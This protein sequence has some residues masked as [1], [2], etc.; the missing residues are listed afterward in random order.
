MASP[1]KQSRQDNRFEF[2]SA[3]SMSG[4]EKPIML[5]SELRIIEPLQ[6]VDSNKMPTMLEYDIY[7]TRPV[8]PGPQTRFRVSG[9]FMKRAKATDA[10]P[11]PVWTGIENDSEAKKVLLA[12]NWFEMLIKSID[13][14]YNHDR[15]SSFNESSRVLPH[16]N[17]F[18]YHHM[19][20]KIKK[21]LFPEMCHPAHL[22]PANKDDFTAGNEECKVWM[23]YSKHIFKVGGKFEFG[24]TPTFLWPFHQSPTHWTDPKN[25]SK[26]LPL[27]LFG[28]IFT[29]IYFVDNTSTIFKKKAGNDADYKFVLQSM[30]LVLEEI[31]LPPLAERQ[32]NQTKKIMQYPGVSRVQLVENLSGGTLN[33]R[34]KFQNIPLPEAVLIFAVNKN[35]APGTW[36]FADDE[37]YKNVFMSHNIESIEII[38]DEKTYHMKDLSIGS[39]SNDIMDMKAF[40]DHVFVPPMGMPV[41]LNKVKLNSLKEG[42]SLSAYPHI[43]LPLTPYNNKKTRLIP[44]YD[45]TASSLGKRSDLKLNIKF[46]SAGT[47]G[48]TAD[49]AYVVTAIWTDQSLSF[50]P[51]HSKFINPY[52][53]VVLTHASN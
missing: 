44:Y 30:D 50:D 14:Y 43:Y 8:M 7:S 25:P 20:D 31:R 4:K 11:N 6:K 22:T 2:P 29:R 19:D 46:K 42:A 53:G 33:H 47:P 12:P 41:D 38:F 24:F 5:G 45:D 26:V 1:S 27:T 37:N 3:S 34:C 49:V 35:V 13:V 10:A 15:I 40:V 21:L 48:S 36:S 18:I 39:I 52:S 32:L 16:M 23:D 9:K 51:A 28:H 17:A